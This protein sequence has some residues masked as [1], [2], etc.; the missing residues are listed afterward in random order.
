MAADSSALLRPPLA[1]VQSPSYSKDDQEQGGSIEDAPDLVPPEEPPYT[2]TDPGTEAS[3]LERYQ[4]NLGTCYAG[5]LAEVN[6][7]RRTLVNA[8]Y[9]DHQGAIDAAMTAVEEA[10]KD[11]VAMQKGL[12]Q[13][14][15]PLILTLPVA[16][17]VASRYALGD[18]VLIDF[19]VRTPG[20]TGMG[21]WDSA[22][23]IGWAAETKQCVFW[24]VQY[25]VGPLAYVGPLNQAVADGDNGEPIWVS[26]VVGT[27]SYSFL[28]ENPFGQEEVDIVVSAT[29][30]NVFW[31]WSDEKTDNPRGEINVREDVYAAA[32]A[33]SWPDKIWMQLW[34]IHPITKESKY[35]LTLRGFNNTLVDLG[36]SVQNCFE[37]PWQ[38]NLA[39]PGWT[40]TNRSRTWAV[41]VSD[42]RY[43][44]MPDS[45]TIT[46]QGGS[47]NYV[48]SAES[49][50]GMPTFPMFAFVREV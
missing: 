49:C 24:D 26:D 32:I 25:S 42:V 14:A 28:W 3:C 18:Q 2:P 19:P 22:R 23:V 31:K 16:H 9:A 45:V 21:V 6:E 8:C 34:D 11:V 39:A 48:K 7:E 44:S 36:L 30:K 4:Y 37:I 20:T 5:A 50:T 27:Y 13:P 15:E 33:L 40:L 29:G 1:Y 10:E 43:P 17:C 46:N 41:L 47:S 12:Y 38:S 35:Y